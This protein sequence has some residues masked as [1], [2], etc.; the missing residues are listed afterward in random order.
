MA[1]TANMNVTVTSTITTSTTESHLAHFVGGNVH[2]PPGRH[3]QTLFDS[4]DKWQMTK[5]SLLEGNMVL[6]PLKTFD[7]L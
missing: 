2:G 5:T 7:I 3:T 6:S 1:K 4:S